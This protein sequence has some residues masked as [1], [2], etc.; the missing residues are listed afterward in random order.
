MPSV[1][2][3][4]IMSL[5]A[6]R[7][8]NKS[9]SA[10]QMAMQRL[11]SG[12][13]LN[14][15]KDDAA[16]LAIADRMTAQIRGLNQAAR[17]ANDGI[18]LAQTAEGALGEI[19]TSLQRLRE[20]AVQS[21]NATNTA[22]DRAS[23]QQEASQLLQEIDRVSGQT[24]FNGLKLLDGSFKAQSFQ[25][26]ANAGQTI[27]VTMRSAQ[28]KNLGT[29]DASAVSSTPTAS[30]PAGGAATAMASGDVNVNGVT[31]GA[32][33]AAAD[34]QSF[35]YNAG[36]SIAKAAAFNAVSDKTGVA[37]TVNATEVEGV[38]MTGAPGGASGTLY[39]NGVATDTVYTTTDLAATRQSVVTAIN[40]KSDQTG[41]VAVD[42]GS[43]RGGVKLVAADGRNIAIG[44]DNGLTA[45]DVGL[46]ISGTDI[47]L[48]TDN[49]D[50]GYQV[51]YG[52]FTLSSTK[53]I[54]IEQGT[55]NILNTG[56][57]AGVYAPQTAYV[58][59]NVL[60]TNQAFTA[61]DFK[62]NGILIGN[63]LG[64]YDKASFESAPGEKTFSAIAKA[65]AVNAIAEQTDVSAT[66]NTTLA[67][68]AA[69]SAGGTGS[70]TINGVAAATITTSGTDFAA[71][72]AIVVQA[73]NAI[74]GQTGVVA[75]DTNDDAKGVQLQ[76]A[77]GRNIVVDAATGGFAGDGSNT[78]LA[79]D[80]VYTGSITL[81]S[82]KSFAI[83]SGATGTDVTTTLGLEVGT[84]GAGKSGQALST[85]D[86]S[87][88]EGAT[89]ALTAI[90]NALSSI[91]SGRGD[92]G[93]VQ[94]R[95]S[96]T[97]SALQST[98]E[99][100]SAARSRIQ[101]ADFAE[102]TANLSRAQI[103]QQAGTAMLAQANA[104]TQNVLTL[105]RGG[106]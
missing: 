70:I 90:D 45:N 29:G 68:G 7:Q 11:S 71:D 75:V 52:S 95:F 81:N 61:G 18:S 78:G 93:A 31:I 30:A 73:I 49:L 67:A 103:L 35:A 34:N 53:D 82:A 58:S 33:V 47:A 48:A 40:A 80:G 88:F 9:Q 94:N 83:E 43:D 85:I 38:D 84:Y 28:T 62:I 19:T 89:A 65:A 5:N 22:S 32:S 36:S 86:L 74:A 50:P 54:K 46:N 6:Q 56:L 39:I 72:R 96:S 27:S 77:D 13:R 12:L 55:G 42:T 104:S 41:V 102:E 2:N 1:I 14:S 92:L 87:T 69:A 99:N 24:E 21:A 26:G 59:T 8:L 23:L 4:N 79:A 25:I 76:A 106:G 57:Q 64:S 63:S 44:A 10:M 60:T 20:L 91:D 100:L 16:G 98:S 3:T 105:L 97:I 51:F 101:D 37:A 66:V 15:A 17:N